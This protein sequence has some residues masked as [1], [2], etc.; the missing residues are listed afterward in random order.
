MC[1]LCII[2]GAVSDKIFAKHSKKASGS[3]YISYLLEKKR[4]EDFILN[5][6]KVLTVI[7]AKEEKDKLDEILNKYFENLSLKKDVNLQAKKMFVDELK[8]QDLIDYSGMLLIVMNI[9]NELKM[10][11][12]SVKIKDFTNILVDRLRVFHNE[13]KKYIDSLKRKYIFIGKIKLNYFEKIK[14]QILFNYEIVVDK[15]KLS[16]YDKGVLKQNLNILEGLFL[17]YKRNLEMNYNISK[18]VFINSEFSDT[19]FKKLWDFNKNSFNDLINDDYKANYMRLYNNTKRLISRLAQK[20]SFLQDYVQLSDFVLKLSGI[21]SMSFGL[22]VIFDES[23]FISLLQEIGGGSSLVNY[24]K[25]YDFDMVRD[26]FM[27]KL[28]DIVD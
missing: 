23:V 15:Y 18:E 3:E 27:D 17:I 26:V 4:D 5:N 13:R 9:N 19:N 10:N 8:P 6:L 25:M 1:D 22:S 20:K 7:F 28:L 12:S 24:G 21:L 11:L 16:P 14:R 2:M